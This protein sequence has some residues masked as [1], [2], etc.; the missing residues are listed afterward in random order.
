MNA[1]EIIKDLFV[2]NGGSIVISTLRGNEH[3]VEINPKNN[4]IKSKTG[5]RNQELTLD[6]FDIVV[7]FLISNNGF[8]K[9][10]NGRNSKIGEGKCT[11]D[12]ICGCIATK[13]YGRNIGE[14]TFDPVFIISAILDKAKICEN[15][16]GYLKLNSNFNSVK[17]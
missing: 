14:S 11:L 13:Y 7:D 9:K 15:G 6:I 3:I 5:L 8:S 16:Y 17:K 4:C 2:S 1:S 10:G 12:T